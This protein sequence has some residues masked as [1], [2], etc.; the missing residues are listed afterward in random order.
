MSDTR[1]RIADHVATNPGVHFNGLVRALGLA[2]GQVQ[3]HV[4]RLRDDGRVV[5]EE[6]CG[7][8]HYFPEGYGDWERGALALLRRETSADVVALLLARGETAPGEVAEALDLAGSTVAYHVDRL[9]EQDVLERRRGDARVRLAV[10]R[11]TATA[12]LLAA[13]N[14][15]LPGRLVDRF[16]RLVDRLLEDAGGGG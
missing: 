5:V 13:A 10:C 12:E 14:Q 7:R 16:V 6:C 9:V 8:T 2:T 4:K 1:D 15:P 3:Y 11:P